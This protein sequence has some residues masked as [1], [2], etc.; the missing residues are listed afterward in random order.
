MLVAISAQNGR[1]CSLSGRAKF[2]VELVLIESN[3]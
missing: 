2:V 1:G 3:R